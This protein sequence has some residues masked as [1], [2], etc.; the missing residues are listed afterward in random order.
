MGLLLVVVG[1][2]ALAALTSKPATAHGGDGDSTEEAHQAMH[3]MMEAAHGEEAVERMHD[4][5]G[6]EEM[7][8]HC[9]EMMAAMEG[10]DGMDG[11]GAGMMGRMM[12]GGPGGM[13]SGM[14]GR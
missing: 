11:M 3:E 10:M 5:D 12:D 8:R 1:L 4:V 9:V 13:G 7:V 14:R 6:A 2:L